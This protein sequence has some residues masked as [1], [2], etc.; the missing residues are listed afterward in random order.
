M[1]T[2]GRFDA[3]L[4]DLDGV[5]T[6]TAT[7]HAA[8]WKQMFDTFL[9]RHR[10]ET[11]GEPLE[12]FDIDD[13]YRRYVDGKPRYDGVLSFLASR[14]IELP[15]GEPD[16]PPAADTVA[17]LGNRKNELV[18]E[19]IE[20][21][22]V[23]AFPDSVRLVE[24]LRRRGIRTA[25]VSSSA[26]TAAVLRSAGIAHLFD[27]RVDGTVAEELGLAGKPAPDTFLE[28]AR[29]L[30]VA[31]QRAVVVEDALAGVEAGSA[32]GFGLVIGVDRLDQAQALRDH[33]ADLVVTDLGE[34]LPDGAGPDPSPD[35]RLDLP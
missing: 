35:P 16:D 14:G 2:A 19:L 4:F 31:A 17:G 11:R 1:L 33:G 21:E 13:D 22:G 23:G 25:V 10:A 26:N 34:L 3:V 29:R 15:E 32:G 8:A 7:L 6:E 20:I 27:A 28:A 30:D 18:V 9:L 12:L 24:E 5:L